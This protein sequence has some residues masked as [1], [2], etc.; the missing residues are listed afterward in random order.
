MYQF[1]LRPEE[2]NAT[3]RQPDMMKFTNKLRCAAPLPSTPT[4]AN[5]TS[6]TYILGDEGDKIELKSALN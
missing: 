6:K 3:Q 2:D 4:A 5:L 1:I